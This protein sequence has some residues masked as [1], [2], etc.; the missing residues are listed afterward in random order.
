MSGQKE[1]DLVSA[2]KL[3]ITVAE[4]PPSDATTAVQRALEAVRHQLGLAACD[5]R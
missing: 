1:H 4:L 3:Q 2:V 5:L